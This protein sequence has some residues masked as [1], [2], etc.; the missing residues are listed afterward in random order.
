MNLHLKKW[1]NRY[2]WHFGAYLGLWGLKISKKLHLDHLQSRYLARENP[3][4]PHLD[5]HLGHSTTTKLATDI[6]SF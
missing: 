3:F 4:F 5:R 2:F 6:Y 1:G